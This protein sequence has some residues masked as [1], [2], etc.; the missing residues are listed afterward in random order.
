MK[1]SLFMYKLKEKKLAGLWPGP[2]RI[3][4]KNFREAK[5]MGKKQP[6]R[7]Y[8]EL[9]ALVTIKNGRVCLFFSTILSPRD[10]LTVKLI[11]LATSC[12][13]TTDVAFRY[14]NKPHEG[15]PI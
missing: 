7:A 14:M 8:W 3:S 2:N 6:R 12:L 13:R 1:N 5:G 11:N 10:N 15:I 9:Q 4:E